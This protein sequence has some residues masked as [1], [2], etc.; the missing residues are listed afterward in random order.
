MNNKTVNAP[1]TIIIEY[2]LYYTLGG[3]YS[4]LGCNKS[5]H[6]IVEGAISVIFFIVIMYYFFYLF[7]SVLFIPLKS[8]LCFNS[9]INLVS[10]QDVQVDSQDIG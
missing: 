10:L 2:Q 3:K 6:S 9:I 4:H 5:W 7:G 1:S 8:L